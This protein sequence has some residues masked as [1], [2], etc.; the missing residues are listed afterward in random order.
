[1]TIPNIRINPK[2]GGTVNLNVVKL[3]NSISQLNEAIIEERQDY[4]ELMIDKKVF[5]VDQNINAKGASANELLETVPSIDID[6][7]GNISLR[8]SQNVTILIDGKPSGL[9]GA[10]RQ[11]LLEQIPS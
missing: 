1:M 3:K 5:H 4:M 6:I 8:G 2:N 9:T 7:D 10:G 11:V